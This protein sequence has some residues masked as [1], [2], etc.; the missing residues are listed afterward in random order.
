MLALK[1][2]VAVALA[3][4][5]ARAG[6]ADETPWERVPHLT[7]PRLKTAPV[8]D[9]T[10][11]RAEWIAAAQLGPLKC[12]PEG[13]ADEL[14]RRVFMGYDERNVYIGWQ[15]FRPAMAITPK[16]P[17]QTGRVDSTGRGDLV[18]LMFAPETGS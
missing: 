11:D 15:L 2:H 4:L 6:A 1:G 14:P 9:G 8:I 7:V 18:E 5:A 13:V 3:V 17:L 16:A 12:G 10:V